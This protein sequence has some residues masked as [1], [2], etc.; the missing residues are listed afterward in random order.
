M[1]DAFI[2]YSRKNSVFAAWLERR[3]ERYRLPRG[4]AVERRRLRIFRDVQDLVG[5]ELSVA[6]EQALRQSE[7][8]IVVCSPQARASEWVDKEIHSFVAHHGADRLIPVIVDGRPNVEVGRDDEL[9]DQAFP[10]ALLVHLDE[11]LA[12]DFRSIPIEGFVARRER[13]QEALFQLLALLYGADKDALL[14]R[15]LRRKRRILALGLAGSLV[16]TVLFAWLAYTA[17]QN[18][19]IAVARQL[20]AEALVVDDGTAFGLHLGALLGVESLKRRRTPAGVEMA[21]RMTRRLLRPGFIEQVGAGASIALS[22]N[23]TWL[24]AATQDGAEGSRIRVWRLAA[25]STDTMQVLYRPRAPGSLAVSDGDLVRIATNEFMDG[26]Q[27][28]VFDLASH[29]EL[30]RFPS[31]DGPVALDGAGRHL[32]IIGPE[33]AVEVWEIEAPR[34][35][36]VLKPTE[37]IK[38]FALGADGTLLAM[39]TYND[40]VEVWDLASASRIRPST[41]IAGIIESREAMAEDRSASALTAWGDLVLT[42]DGSGN[43]QL[44]DVH[45]QDELQRGLHGSRHIQHIALSAEGVHVAAVSFGG[46][47]RAWSLDRRTLAGCRPGQWSSLKSTLSGDATR[48]AFVNPGGVEVCDA[49]GRPVVARLRGSKLKSIALSQDGHW[50][51]ATDARNRI[52]VWNV[53]TGDRRARFRTTGDKHTDRLSGPIRVSGDGRHVASAVQFDMVEVFDTDTGR[54]LL[55]VRGSGGAVPSRAS[56]N[57]CLSTDGRHLV[58][59]DESGFVDVWEIVSERVVGRLDLGSQV[60]TCSFG[61]EDAFFAT[62]TQKGTVRL[63]SMPELEELARI[64]LLPGID[65]ICFGRDGRLVVV[66]DRGQ[67]SEHLWQPEALIDEACARLLV[68]MSPGKWRQYLGEASY[69]PTCPNL[70][71]PDETRRAGT[72][73]GKGVVIEDRPRF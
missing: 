9:Q 24:A 32:A 18:R 66:D 17:E 28:F 26:N 27:A 41:P 71:I 50:L 33:G 43:V 34:R 67:R 15:H 7:N 61:L 73:E 16:L 25:A 54:K 58:V 49:A 47:L 22:P 51:A 65:A 72:N 56:A 13:R 2:S 1:Y 39:L 36:V 8:L 68:N 46:D 14:Q 62:Y 6:I 40:R 12:A 42:G 38:A 10:R 23:G 64:R 48:A 30:A 11:P 55:K 60:L 59:G 69:R 31:G 57:F 3:L 63:W 5:N 35:R 21:E 20:A 37:K 52:S 45:R 4:L 19:R 70:K 29:R 44:W 53:D